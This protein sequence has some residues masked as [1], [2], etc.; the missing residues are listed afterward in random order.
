MRFNRF[1]CYRHTL[2]S[3]RFAASLWRSRRNIVAARWGLPPE[4]G[5]YMAELDVTY[6]CD[7]RC[8]MCQ[9]WKDRRQGELTLREYEK[10][11]E[12]FYRMGTHLVSI[13]GGEPLLREDIFS[14]IRRLADYGMCVNVCTNGLLL[15]EQAE[16]LCSSGASFVTV[17]LD[18][19]TAGTHDK[20]RGAPGSYERIERGIQMLMAYPREIRPLVRVRMT[21]S[22]QNLGE[23][24]SYYRKWHEIVDDVLLQPSHY[25]KSA[26]Y[27]G[28]DEEA[29]RVDPERL[30][31]QVDGTPLKR[32]GYIKNLITSLKKDGTYPVQR[33]YAGILM[34]R[35]DP[36]GNVFPC[37]EQHVRVG[38]V[39]EQAFRTIWHS[40]SFEQ[41]RREIAKN[42][43]CKCWYNNTA[44]ISH[45]ARILDRKTR[46]SF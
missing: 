17:S 10:L 23:V 46:H 26:F 27:T 4:S 39:R 21:V 41:A 34:V 18:G 44:L 12:D 5:P 1:W 16:A 19:A 42:R 31:Q 40:D 6:R 24:K 9:R 37:L 32:D 25:C 3:L 36:W 30:A 33:C 45:Y 7:C 14:I 43:N 29:F 2:L 11:A 13:A 35:L 15:D 20:V 22:N 38:S 28:T 8:Q